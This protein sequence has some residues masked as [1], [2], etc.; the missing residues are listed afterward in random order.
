MAETIHGMYR[1][2]V[3]GYT[4]KVA[5]KTGREGR[6]SRMTYGELD[7]WVDAVAAKLVSLGVQKGDAVGILSGNRPQWVVADLA[8]LSL[9]ACVVPLYPTLPPSYLQYIINDSKMTVLVAGDPALLTSIS[10]VMD[11]TPDPWSDPAARRCGHR[12]PLRNS[13]EQDLL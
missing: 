8:V 7:K 4:D 12:L 3:A 6:Y 5:L 10:T 2:A 11:E 1:K 13:G 9:G